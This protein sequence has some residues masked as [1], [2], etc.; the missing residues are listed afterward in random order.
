MIRIVTSRRLEFGWRNKELHKD[1]GDEKKKTCLLC[2]L[3]SASKQFVSFDVIIMRLL[4]EKRR[5]L[6]MYENLRTPH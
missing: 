1:L 6:R 5:S 2:N 3:Q 4:Q